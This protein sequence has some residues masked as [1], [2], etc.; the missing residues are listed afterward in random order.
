MRSRFVVGTALVII[1][2]ALI[3]F[4][5]L[6]V[7]TGNLGGVSQ[8]PPSS[9]SARI[10]ITP[11]AFIIGTPDLTAMRDFSNKGMGIKL[12]YPSQ[13]QKAERGLQLMLSPSAA[14]L[15]SE[16]IEDT[17]VRVGIPPDSVA[18]EAELLRR[19]QSELA[20]QYQ[21]LESGPRMIGDHVWQ[22]ATIQFDHPPFDGPAVALIAATNRNDVGYYLVGLA[23][24][25]QWAGIQPQ[26]QAILD[27]FA[28][29]TEAV[30]APHGRYP[31]PNPHRNT[32]AGNLCC[33]A[34]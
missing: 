7:V 2:F 16:S 13:W 20:A 6:S 8:S 4:V 14:G 10:A 24:A 25:E 30:F 9:S 33:A 11:A 34:G 22:S 32:D 17:L 1:T 23:P 31:T 19:T 27:S 28:F 15:S 12:Q 3:G 18:D 5:A 29:T 26:I 21:L